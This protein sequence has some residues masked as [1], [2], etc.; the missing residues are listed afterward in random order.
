MARRIHFLVRNCYIADPQ[1]H[2]WMEA[3]GSD[4]DY[5]IELGASL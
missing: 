5:M 1:Y 4:N 2:F 3:L